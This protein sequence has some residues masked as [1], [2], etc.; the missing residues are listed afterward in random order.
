M[1]LLSAQERHKSKVASQVAKRGQQA[2]RDSALVLHHRVLVLTLLIHSLR[3][4]NQWQ[5]MHVFSRAHIIRSIHETIASSLQA[6]KL[7]LG[8]AARTGGSRTHRS[9]RRDR[10]NRSIVVVG[11]PA[12]APR[13]GRRVGY[14][15][16]VLRH[17]NRS[18]S[19]RVCTHNDDVFERE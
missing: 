17:Q 9:R 14:L 16:M 10:D 15:A 13:H 11:R 4:S 6:D 18:I 5:R 2:G 1:S 12:R 3:I 19:E 8:D 7:D